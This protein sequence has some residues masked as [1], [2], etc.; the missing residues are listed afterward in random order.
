MTSI[1]NSSSCVIF[2]FAAS[3]WHHFHVPLLILN[4]DMLDKLDNLSLIHI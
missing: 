2:K 3:S 4:D 1:I